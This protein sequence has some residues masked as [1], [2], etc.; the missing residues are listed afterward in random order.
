M[1][2]GIFTT[3]PTE[4]VVLCPHPFS[5]L[6]PTPPTA[7]CVVVHGNCVV[8]V[9][10]KIEMK[11]TSTTC[12]VEGERG[13]GAGPRPVCVHRCTLCACVHCGAV[14]SFSTLCWI[15]QLVQ[16]LHQSRD[17]KLPESSL[18]D[19]KIVWLVAISNLNI[20]TRPH[21]EEMQNGK[22]TSQKIGKK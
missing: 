3:F 16:K 2:F 5:T 19:W 8:A 4:A 14:L 12:G 10:S 7:P 22:W 21:K 9:A 6:S 13:G 18:L 20:F 1:T 11:G 17:S 15:M